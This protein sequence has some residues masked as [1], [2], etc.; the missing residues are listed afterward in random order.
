[1]IVQLTDEVEA[2]GI[3]PGGRMQIPARKY[4]VLLPWM[5]GPQENII[6]YGT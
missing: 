6:N 2:Y 5:I 4:Y 3:Y 1:M